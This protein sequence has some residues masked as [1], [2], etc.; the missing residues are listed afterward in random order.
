M[1]SVYWVGAVAITAVYESAA[2]WNLPEASA[3]SA[4][5]RSSCNR[6]R[7]RSV[8]E[9]LRKA[10]SKRPSDELRHLVHIM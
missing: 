9:L 3:M 2:S 4:A 7:R 10:A 6:E 5:L 1:H 8:A